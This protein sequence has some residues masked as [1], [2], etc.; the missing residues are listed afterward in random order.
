[1]ISGR[2]NRRD[3]LGQ[4]LAAGALIGFPAIVPANALGRG[5]RASAADRINL[6]VIGIG[7]RCTY[8]LKGMLGFGDLQ[9]VTIADVQKKRREAG[10]ALVDKQYG[11]DSCTIVRDFREILDRKDIDAVLIA[12]GDRWHAPASIL[13]ARAGKDVYSEKPCGLTIELCQQLD[14]TIRNR[15]RVFQAGTQ[16]RSVPNFQKAVEIAHSGKLG[17]VHT[18]YASVYVPSIETAWLP[19]EPTPPKDEV[20][21]DLWLGPAPW[22][23]YNHAYVEGKWRG[24]YDFDS[25]GR[26]LDWGAHTLD[27]CQ[28]ANKA[29]DTMPVEYEPTETNVTCRYANGVKLVLDF[30]KTPFGERPGWVQRL[31][32]CPVRFVGDDGWIETGDSGEIVC[33]IPSVQAELNAAGS[34]TSGLDVAAHARN[35]LDAIK[36]RGTT[37]A[38]S[39]VMRRSHIACHAAATAWMLN[40]KL[41]IDPAK[42][43]FVNDDEANSLRGRPA[44]MPWDPARNYNGKV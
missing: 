34:P 43:Q 29:D 32:T 7:P 35:F 28:W 40:R 14:D 3:F 41:T 33:S 31:G 17:K 24:Q 2:T 44:R 16:R 38:N 1:M 8:D 22:R 36:S 10:K 15:H 6:G 5:T 39:Q 18:L 37:A 11:N 9:C 19:G 23:P 27:L 42:E 25:G 12:T 20:D 21:W 4:S 30:L 13:A 26:L